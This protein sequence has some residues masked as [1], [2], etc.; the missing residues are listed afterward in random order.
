MGRFVLPRVWNRR[1]AALNDLTFDELHLR[2]RDRVLEVG[3]GG[4]YLLGRIAGAVTDG[5]VAGID[6]SPQIVGFC[7]RRFRSL[8]KRGCLEVRCASAEDIPYPSGSFTKACTVNTLFYFSDASRA[9]R[10]LW[11][12]LQEGGQAAICFTERQFLEGRSFAA[13]GLNLYEADEVRGMMVSAG[14]RDIRLSRGSD[15]WREFVCLV[16]TK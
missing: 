16:G 12:V 7:E 3:C 2:P 4:G 13:Q 10:E 1:N 6:A 11:R 15:R 8:V 9:M 14:F 5:F